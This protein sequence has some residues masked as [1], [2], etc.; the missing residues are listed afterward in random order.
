MRIHADMQPCL[1]CYV[2][3]S[4]PLCQ[5]HIMPCATGAF[6]LQADP[7]VAPEDLRFP[8][9]GGAGQMQDGL[10]LLHLQ[11][12][13][14][15][16][17]IGLAILRK[18]Q[19]GD[20][21]L[22]KDIQDLHQ[23]QLLVMQFRHGYAPSGGVIPCQ[24]M[25][26]LDRRAGGGYAV[27]EVIGMDF[28]TLD[29][30]LA[31]LPG[32]AQEHRDELAGHRAL[33]LLET[34]QGRKVYIALEDGAVRISAAGEAPACTVIADENDLLSMMAG[35]L[36]PAKALMFGKVKVKGTPKPLLELIA[37]LK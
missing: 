21:A 8:S 34:K 29:E 6:R 36:N 22:T 3:D 20:A 37:L 26:R 7:V 2:E 17:H 19:P 30:L 33:F 13:I 10:G 4:V 28:N 18:R 31:A 1:L 27:G 15:G 12:K 23:V 24:Y 9:G 35:R 25:L 5:H 16:H 14:H 32:L 11:L